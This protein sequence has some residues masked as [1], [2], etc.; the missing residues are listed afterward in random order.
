MLTRRQVLAGTAAGSIAAIA[1]AR[2]VA[3]A[4]PGS[5]FDVGFGKLDGGAA[6]AFHKEELGFSFFIKL[7]DG[8]A[9][10][11][12]KEET[13][14]VIGVFLKFSKVEATEAAFLK[15][16]WTQVGALS[17][18]VK[19]AADPGAGF[20]KL[21]SSLAQI[22]LKFENSDRQPVEDVRLLQGGML[23]PDKNSCLPTEIG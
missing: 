18:Y 19:D 21:D 15:V 20:Y 11:F 13:L 2:G 12:Y 1:S 3:A 10:V 16:A 5:G 7:H 14:G 6:A 22:F 4:A 9:Q 23:I 17:G 8:A